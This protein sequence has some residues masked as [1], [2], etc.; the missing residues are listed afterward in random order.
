[1]FF[2][3]THALFCVV[4]KFQEYETRFKNSQ[5]DTFPKGDTKDFVLT[6]WL[7]QL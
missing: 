2:L 1:M 6:M 7:A 3:S 4:L 5:W